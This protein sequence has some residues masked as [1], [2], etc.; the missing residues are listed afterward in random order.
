MRRQV[1]GET[2]NIPPI[3]ERHRNRPSMSV[4]REMDEG[5]DTEGSLERQQSLKKRSLT[6][7]IGSDLGLSLDKDFDRVIEAQ[8]VAFTLT[9]SHSA[10]FSYDR[11]VSGSNGLPSYYSYAHISP[12]T[13]RGYLMRQNTKVVVASSDLDKGT[14][15]AG[16]SPVKTQRPQ[17]WTVEP[18]NGQMRQNS[19]RDKTSP[20][21]KTPQGPMPPMP[22]HESNALTAL[23]EETMP[24]P[25][26]DESGERGRLFVKVMG[27]KDLDLP[28]PKS[29]LED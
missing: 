15:S 23:A 29:E 18:W 4:E 14:R 9:P 28:L 1:S 22:G 19:F 17:S 16:N 21:K 13:Q 7:D 3:P 26:V 20:R 27:V 11:Q 8:K 10:V 24:E 2:R 25:T 6:L 12:R 5:L